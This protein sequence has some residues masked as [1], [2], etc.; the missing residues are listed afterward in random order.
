MRHLRH[1]QADS[2]VQQS[3]SAAGCASVATRRDQLLAIVAENCSAGALLGRWSRRAR[4]RS[5]WSVSGCGRADSSLR[6][7]RVLF[8]RPDLSAR[9]G[10]REEG[11]K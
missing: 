2:R 7:R 4:A 11:N 5:S 3:S 10:D 6:T 8:D 1:L 9:R